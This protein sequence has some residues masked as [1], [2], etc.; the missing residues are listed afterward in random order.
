MRRMTIHAARSR[1]SVA[2]IVLVLSALAIVSGTL[3]P[4]TAIGWLRETVPYFAAL[5]DWL[6]ASLPGWNPL[7]VILYA[8]LALL[9][10]WLA[11]GRLFWRGLLWMAGFSALSEL[12]QRLV[13]GRSARLSDVLNDLLGIA[14]GCVLALLLHRLQRGANR[15]TANPARQPESQA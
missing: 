2:W 8:W 7:H 3:A 14:L 12:L 11:S 13:P 10:W 15:R 5:W 6:D 1:L 4:A 9:W